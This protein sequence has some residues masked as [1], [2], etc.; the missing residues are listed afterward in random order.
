M[1][2]EQLTNL[3]EMYESFFKFNKYEGIEQS[4]SAVGAKF[5]SLPVLLSMPHSV[6]HYRNGNRKEADDYTGA[7]GLLMNDLTDCYCIYSKKTTEE[8]PNYVNGGRYKKCLEEVIVKNN[9]LFMID[10]HGASSGRTFDIDL[11]T[12]N[13]KSADFKHIEMMKQVFSKYHI[14]DVRE[15]DTFPALH[16]G[17]VTSFVSTKLNIPC[18]QMEIHAKYRTPLENLTQ[19]MKLL[20]S[21]KEIVMTL[22]K[23]S[24]EQ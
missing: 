10:L 2:T 18:V 19:F 17:T 20:D 24:R 15:N 6:V 22:S 3:T 5:G 16:P 14:L 1:D 12:M 8:D 9:I 11:G 4:N 13:G 7:I 23:E 21:L